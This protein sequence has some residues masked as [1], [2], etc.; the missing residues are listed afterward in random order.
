M[1]G[2]ILAEMKEFVD[3]TFGADAWADLLDGSGLGSQSYDVTQSY[4]DDHV[5]KIVAAASRRSGLSMNAILERFGEFIAPHL[6]AIYPLL[7]SP[8]WKTLH[9]CPN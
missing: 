6:L 8:D 4:A 5:R 9:C 7:V 1:H 3:S 2:I